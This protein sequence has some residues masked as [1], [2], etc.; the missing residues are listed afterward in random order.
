MNNQMPTGITITQ[1]NAY[2]SYVNKYYEETEHAIRFK[3]ISNTIW[4]IT[5]VRNNNAVNYE[6]RVC[7]F[8]YYR[9]YLVNNRVSRF[10]VLRK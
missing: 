1:L 9:I 4:D 3:Q 5:L 10:T 7:Y 6:D 8:N 2:A